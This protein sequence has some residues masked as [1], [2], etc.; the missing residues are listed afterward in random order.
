M[1]KTLTACFHPILGCLKA[2]EQFLGKD[3]EWR[4]VTEKQRAFLEMVAKAMGDADTIKELSKIASRSCADVNAWLKEKGFNIQLDELDGPYFC[5]AS[6]L[7]VSVDWKIPGKETL[8]G[9]KD[10]NYVGA[11][12]EHFDVFTAPTTNEKVVCL[13]AKT[14]ER[15]FLVMGEPPQDELQLMKHVRQLSASLRPDRE[16]YSNLFFPKVALDRNEDISW[17]C[18]LSTLDEHKGENIIAQA[19]QQ[20]KFRLDHLGAHVESAAAMAVKRVFDTN[21][22]IIINRPFYVWLERDGLSLPLFA[23]YLDTD[24][25]TPVTR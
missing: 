3:R 24:V 13:V 6:V 4:G 2:A 18:G 17:L 9:T 19:L 5:V 1:S 20:T 12:M 25:W 21:P 7:D 15:L 14:G 16:R 23:A 22:S 11:K 8:V 10:G